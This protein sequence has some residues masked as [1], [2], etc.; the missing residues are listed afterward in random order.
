MSK[1]KPSSSTERHK[2]AI[3][4]AWQKQVG[5]IIE[6]GRQLIAAKKDLGHGRFGELF[7]GPDA[8]PFSI[9]VAQALMKIARHPTLSKAE[10][11]P[12]LP[13]SWST[14]E[15]LSRATPTQL[16]KWLAD[17]TVNAATP[18]E[19]AQW[20]VTPKQPKVINDPDTISEIPAGDLGL[21]H[22]SAERSQTLELLKRSGFNMADVKGELEDIEQGAIGTQAPMMSQTASQ[23]VVL[24]TQID[25]A[26]RCI[27]VE[28]SIW[29]CKGDVQF[30][31]WVLQTISRLKK[32]LL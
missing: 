11:A 14:L 23:A 31:Q 22:A 18:R 29:R 32:M 8:V 21:C 10:H 5:S 4:T 16:K 26:L 25:A 30:E 27:E 24:Q 13:T 1:P 15:I 28:R 9:D 17:G 12:Y 7:E 2:L 3:R 6:T 19:T 20:L